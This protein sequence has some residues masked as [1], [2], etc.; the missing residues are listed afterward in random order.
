M[1]V[2]STAVAYKGYLHDVLQEYSQGSSG[3]IVYRAMLH[4]EILFIVYF[5]Y[6]LVLEW[7]SPVSHMMSSEL[8]TLQHN[9]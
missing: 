9:R 6:I 7:T 4:K 5:G 8:L 1:S 2:G 3:C